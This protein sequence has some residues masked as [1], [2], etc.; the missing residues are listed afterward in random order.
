MGCGA[1]PVRYS[2]SRTVQQVIR[3][4]RMGQAPYTDSRILPNALKSGYAS[5]MDAVYDLQRDV[6]DDITKLRNL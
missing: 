3:F 4:N 1:K 6:Y 2:L 5:L